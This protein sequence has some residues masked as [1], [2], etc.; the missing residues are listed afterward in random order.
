M[1]DPNRHL[2]SSRRLPFS[3][4]FGRAG[5]VIRAAW[6]LA[7]IACRMVRTLARPTEARSLVNH[8]GRY[9]QG[10]HLLQDVEASTL[11]PGIWDEPVMLRQGNPKDGNVNL[12]ELYVLSC[13]GVAVGE[14]RRV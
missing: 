8:I 10:K 1:W 4:A 6:A 7:S 13:I 2:T 11:F 14:P 12:L 5:S 3:G 9:W